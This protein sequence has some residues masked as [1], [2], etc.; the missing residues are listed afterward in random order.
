MTTTY[1]VDTSTI[2]PIRTKNVFTPATLGTINLGQARSQYV[3]IKPAGTIAVLTVNMP[4]TP[5][6]GDV[7]RV[8]ASQIITALT[9]SGNGNTLNNGLSTFAA[10]G[11][12]EWI[13]DSGTTTWYRFG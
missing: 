5:N 2:E 11:F 10:H 12:G 9:M 4:S 7:V 3:L 13:Y 8:G 1:S 6:D